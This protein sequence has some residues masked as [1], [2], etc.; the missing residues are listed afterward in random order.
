M[1]WGWDETLTAQRKCKHETSQQ[2]GVAGSRSD[3][4][5]KRWS[6]G[7]GVVGGVTC[8]RQPMTNSQEAGAGGCV[9]SKQHGSSKGC[10]SRRAPPLPNR[11]TP[12]RPASSA[13]ST[14]PPDHPSCM[15]S[16]QALLDSLRASLVAQDEGHAAM[17]QPGFP[18]PGW[19]EARSL[20]R[21]HHV[22]R[23]AGPGS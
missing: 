11:S 20:K 21:E 12:K 14:R 3:N 13:T 10:S 6:S 1:L 7:R 23:R 18:I 4:S 8:R 19:A 22:P 9:A 5:D 17:Q 2:G 16:G 15:A